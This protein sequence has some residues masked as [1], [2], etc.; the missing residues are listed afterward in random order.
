MR[1]IHIIILILFITPYFGVVYSEPAVTPHVELSGV[2]S[3]TLTP[4][5]S[6]TFEANSEAVESTLLTETKTTFSIAAT[7]PG[8][9]SSEKHRR[10]GAQVFRYSG[11]AF[12]IGCGLYT[13][14]T[15]FTKFRPA[16][17]NLEYLSSRGKQNIRTN[18]SMDWESA[19]EQRD[20]LLKYST[21]G[22]VGTML[23]LF[24][25]SISFTF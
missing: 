12:G 10:V 2:L 21:I 16:K 15:Y 8:P 1:L 3:G 11:I 4:D 23:G 22:S 20:T 6:F 17:E 7:L 25:F 18:S 9:T 19:K 13:G 14:I 5:T 24:A